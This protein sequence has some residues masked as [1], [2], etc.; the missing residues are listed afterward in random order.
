M[1]ALGLT[2]LEFMYGGV[3]V[4]TSA[5]YGQKWVVRDGIDGI[6]V[7]GPDDVEGAAKAV[8][9]LLNN[10]DERDRMGRNARERAEQFLMSKIVREL[11]GK[12][13]GYLQ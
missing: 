2:Q 3:P 11:A 4:I 5:V 13:E 10:P 12:I 8:E 7:N 6:H 1:E 9:R